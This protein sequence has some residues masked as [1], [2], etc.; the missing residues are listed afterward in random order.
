MVDKRLKGEYNR[1]EVQVALKVGLMCSHP[2]ASER[3]RMREVVRYLDCME[4]PE[5][6]RLLEKYERKNLQV[7]I[8]D[9][10]DF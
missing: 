5:V 2:A 9:Y 1:L 6:K 4:I 8:N 3:P 7:R 10:M